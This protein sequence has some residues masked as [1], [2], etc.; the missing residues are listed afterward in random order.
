LTGVNGDDIG[1]GDAF[2]GEFCEG[3]HNFTG[4]VFTV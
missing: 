2:G 3:F 1:I 4:E